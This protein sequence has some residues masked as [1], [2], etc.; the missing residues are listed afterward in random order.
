MV[1]LL[2]VSIAD[3][4]TIA[5]IGLLIVFGTLIVLMGIIKFLT[6]LSVRKKPEAPVAAAGPAPAPSGPISFSAP[7]KVPVPGSMGDID[8]HTV[9]D[10]TAAMVM[11]IVADDLK[12]PLNTLRFTSIREVGKD[13][14][15]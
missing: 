14:S 7:D 9:E 11:A 4:L 3:T 13:E 2:N 8:L 15:K 1:L 6:V 10:A 5:G 12:A